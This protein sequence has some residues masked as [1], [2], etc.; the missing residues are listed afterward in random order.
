[1]FIFNNYSTKSK[2]YDDSNKLFIVGL[3]PKI[4]P[5]IY[6]EMLQ[7]EVIKDDGIFARQKMRKKK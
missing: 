4:Y 5:F 7:Q 6:I 1:M 2:H 3:Q